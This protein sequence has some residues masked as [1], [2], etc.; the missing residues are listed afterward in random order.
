MPLYIMQPSCQK[1]ESSRQFHS[2]PCAQDGLCGISPL[3]PC[4]SC[5]SPTAAVPRALP[6]FL[7]Q[8]LSWAGRKFIYSTVSLRTSLPY[9]SVCCFSPPP[10]LP[11]CT[12]CLVSSLLACLCFTFVFSRWVPCAPPPSLPFPLLIHTTTSFSLP[13]LAYLTLISSL[14][15]L[16]SLTQVHQ[17]G[18]CW[19]H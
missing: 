12:A 1:V 15:G 8:L 3:P 10:I 5:I 2:L 7:G 19:L 14:H 4:S 18:P 17:L 16:A 6:S 13:S 11:L 9:V